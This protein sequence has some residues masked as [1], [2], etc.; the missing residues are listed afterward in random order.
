M[1]DS[2]NA[3]DPTGPQ[4]GDLPVPGPD[5]IEEQ[6]PEQIDNVVPTRG[7]RLL[8]VVGLGGSAGSIPALRTFFANAPAARWVATAPA[9]YAAGSCSSSSRA[10]TTAQWPYSQP[11]PSATPSFARRLVASPATGVSASA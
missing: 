9:A 3:D 11:A 1:T 8:P 7:Y 6:Y 4:A 10:L 5:V 2:P